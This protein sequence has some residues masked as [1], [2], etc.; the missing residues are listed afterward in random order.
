M[1]QLEK[2]INAGYGCTHIVT[3][4]YTR[5]LSSIHRMVSDNF[6]AGFLWDA[7]GTLV[8]I[9]TAEQIKN[10]LYSATDIFSH[11]N[12][13]MVESKNSIV[14][15]IADIHMFMKD[16]DPA[17]IALMRNV[18]TLA[19]RNRHHIV[20]LSSDQLIADEIKTLVTNVEFNLPTREEIK[21]VVDKMELSIPDRNLTEDEKTAIIDASMGMTLNEAEDA[22]ALSLVTNRNILPEVVMKEKVKAIEYS[23]CLKY[24]NTELTLD[25]VGGNEALINYISLRKRSFS[26]EAKEFGC[27]P[28]KG[29]MMVGVAGTGKSLGAK[30]TASIL[31]RPL[32]T[33][34]VGAVFG[35]LVGQSEQNMRTALK[36]IESISPCVLMLDEI[37]KGLAGS[38]SSGKT[39]G[40]TG[41]RVIGSLL[42]WM[43][44]NE[45]DVYVVATAN[46]ITSLP[47]ELMRKGRFDELFFVDLPNETEREKIIEIHLRKR[48]RNPKD[49][50]INRLAKEMD[51]FTG[52]EIEQV[53]IDSLYVAFGNGT[54][55]TTK[56]ILSVTKDTSP[57][58]VISHEQI[59]R[60]R[61]WATGRCRMASIPQKKTAKKPSTSRKIAV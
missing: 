53:V 52:A 19:S 34:D 2:Y 39:D 15:V 41:S 31:D 30:V 45:S 35:S 44:D 46:D 21:A 36:A 3:H 23:G 58:S 10:D 17:L 6:G 61:K 57:L 4:E 37:E 54:K 48:G 18:I 55:M 40:G 60:L 28:P 12:D 27:P 32:I 50:N 25:D 33:M 24:V 38:K 47:P 8:N 59:E 5:A 22:M 49:F 42:T 16:P 43:N 29:V 26:K 1:K 7:T 56:T 51:G 20:L 13:Y 11:I 14:W 9:I